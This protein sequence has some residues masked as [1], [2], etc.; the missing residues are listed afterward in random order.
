MS[1]YVLGFVVFEEKMRC[2]YFLLDF[3]VEEGRRGE[4]G[5]K[6]H[7]TYS[8]GTTKN[9]K[10]QQQNQTHYYPKRNIITL[11][12]IIVERALCGYVAWKNLV[13][14]QDR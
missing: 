9:T 7:T 12:I 1:R 3:F 13:R 5:E 4:K 10:Q 14:H 11:I 8:I 2:A 6:N